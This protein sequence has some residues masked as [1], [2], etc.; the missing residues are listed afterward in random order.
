MNDDILYKYRVLCEKDGS[1][2]E[3]T[4]K[5]LFNGQIYLSDFESLNDPFEGRI[6]PKYKNITKEKVLKLYPWLI[7]TPDFHNIDWQSE[8][9]ESKILSYLA[10]KMEENLKKYGI[11]SVS[12]D[13]D[14]DLLWSHYADSH[15]GICIGFDNKELEKLKYKIV[16][17][18][19][20]D[21]RPEIEYTDDDSHFQ[22]FI[23]KML[24]TKSINWEYEHE[25]RMIAFEPNDRKLCCF[26]AIKEI[27]LGCRIE[28]NKNF[29]K[30][31]FIKR[32][33]KVHSNCVIKEMRMNVDTLSVE[34]G[35]I[36]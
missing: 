12:S 10:P 27:Y 13:Y 19:I 8:E 11:F 15:R 25:Y 30:E 31:D 5:L 7:E 16:P 29:N 6:V 3:F 32:L 20:S 2:N 33:K 4:E 21:K 18:S 28:K 34:S 26:R 1:L 23:L 14:N 9:V 35:S 36:L 17:V 24:T 22:E